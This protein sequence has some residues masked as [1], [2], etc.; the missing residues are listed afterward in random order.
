[1]TQRLLTSPELQEKII[2][3]LTEEFARSGDRQTVQ[4][5][6]SRGRGTAYDGDIRTWDRSESPAWFECVKAEIELRA[7]EIM[8]ICEED[9]STPGLHRYTLVTRQHYGGKQSCPISLRVDEDETSDAQV[10][11]P[12]TERG[13]TGLMMRGFDQM[14]RTVDRM[15]NQTIGQAFGI[16]KTASDE[17]RTLRE[18]NDKLVQKVR[19][20]EYE[21]DE[22]KWNLKK[23]EREDKV[24]DIKFKAIAQI[25]A[26]VASK[27]GG[28]NAGAAI[29]SRLAILV[30]QFREGLSN[31]QENALAEIFAP[32]QLLA[33]SEIMD[34]AK[35][36][37]SAASSTPP[38]RTNGRTY[39]PSGPGA[40]NGAA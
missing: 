29:P 2:V 14:L 4:L 5:R 6:L 38:N 20:L 13:Q 26:V 32:E 17:A 21:L 11:L 36:D 25:G 27:F 7:I 40:I 9:A 37:A 39:A 34:V 35:R 30:D 18:T 16:A 8:A 28:P 1:M 24:S 12:P 31:D 33:L 3:F 22:R 23:Q 15:H 10:G 19:D